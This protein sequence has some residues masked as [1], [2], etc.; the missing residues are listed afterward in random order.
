MSTS[1][2]A[3]TDERIREAFI[4][5]GGEAAY[6]DP[7]DG[8]KEQRRVAGAVFD[9]WI[10][11][12]DDAV[13]AAID[14]RVL[15]GIVPGV[16]NAAWLRDGDTVRLNKLNGVVHLHVNDRRDGVTRF[17]FVTGTGQVRVERAL[18]AEVLVITPAAVTHG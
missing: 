1:G 6:H 18:D 13:R 5:D 14:W 16:I 7:I 8:D 2:T 17:L 12:H 9:E 10:A 11:A 4:Y 3:W 15:G